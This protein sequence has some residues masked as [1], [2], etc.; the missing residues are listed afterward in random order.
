MKETLS[1]QPVNS[2]SIKV[3]KFPASVCDLNY[4]S[5]WSLIH[6]KTPTV[7]AH[8]SSKTFPNPPIPSK[9]GPKTLESMI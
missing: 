4:G 2:A 9:A 5:A 8:P 6:R 7:T 1:K 3:L